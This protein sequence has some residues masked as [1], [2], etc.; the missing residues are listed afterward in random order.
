V[1]FPLS[2]SNLFGL[3]NNE[4]NIFFGNLSKPVRT[5]IGGISLAGGA[6]VEIGVIAY[7]K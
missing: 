3:L 5:T 7:K 2:D 1:T 4:Y 6:S